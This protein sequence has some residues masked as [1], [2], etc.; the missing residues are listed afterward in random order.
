MATPC[1]LLE[2]PQSLIFSCSQSFALYY[3]VF[4]F[5][6]TFF[7]LL[8]SFIIHLCW[9]YSLYLYPPV[10]LWKTV[11]YLL[12]LLLLLP[13][14]L[15]VDVTAAANVT[16]CYQLSP[17]YLWRSQVGQHTTWEKP[18][19]EP[20]DATPEGNIGCYLLA[21]SKSVWGS[22]V[23]WPTST[24]RIRGVGKQCYLPWE[25]APFGQVQFF[26]QA[27]VLFQPNKNLKVI[28]YRVLR[29]IWVEHQYYY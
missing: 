14:M 12:W 25:A 11:A 24:H 27:T 22:L 15:H 28:V 7:I 4:L 21:D 29:R 6:L 18:F 23:I 20:N 26:G 8:A 19:I 5:S 9:L 16:S 17:L 3:L 10:T 1:N 13:L 2:I